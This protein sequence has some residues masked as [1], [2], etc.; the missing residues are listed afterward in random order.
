MVNNS[1]KKS[2]TS[3]TTSNG[4]NETGVLIFP[5]YDL[6]VDVKKKFKNKEYKKGGLV[7]PSYK[8]YCV[9]KI[10]ME[11]LV[12]FILKLEKNVIMSQY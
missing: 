10:L 1:P 9:L 5:E 3:K 12:H 6:Y 2:N 11:V 8:L 4:N 7:F